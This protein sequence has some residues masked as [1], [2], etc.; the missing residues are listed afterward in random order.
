MLLEKIH[1]SGI[2]GAGGAG[3]PTSKKLNAKAEYLI[4]NAAECEPLLKTDHY[5]MKHFAKECIQAI[6]EVGKIV[7]CENI[8][9]AT[10]NY[11]HEEIACLEA[12][13]SEQNAPITIH[14]MENF[15]PAGDE[16]VMV[17]EV[18]GR[19]VP[20]T[21]IPL[22]VGC[23][24][25]NITTM[26]NI[27]EA[28]E[29]EKPVTE[30]LVTITGAVNKPTMILVPIGTSFSTCLELAGG[31]PL[32]QFI[33]LNGGPMM[34]KI[35]NHNNFHDQVVTK[36]TSGIIILEEKEYLYSLHERQMSQIITQAKAACIQC[37]LCTQLCPRFQ[38]GIPLHPHQVMRHLATS[39]VPD[40]ID[41]DPVWKQAILCCEC[42]ICEVIACPMALSP[43]QVN[44]YVKQR[45][46]E[47]GIR[48]E[49]N[50]EELIPQPMREYQK[51]PP[52]NILLKM[53]LEQYVD[54][55][56]SQL[57]TFEPDEV[58]IPL[59]M[60]IGAPCQP[61][62]KKGD[63]VIKG[64]LI[65]EMEDGKLGAPIH[66]SISGTIICTSDSLI[67]IKKDVA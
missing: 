13:I 63:Q 64:Q 34:G 65:A 18:T 50:G 41:D 14:K 67:Q 59:K 26:L 15:Y 24:V 46:A 29:H 36:T 51:T 23:I 3:F 56:L 38:I 40:D 61:L 55:D 9:I 27:Y 35:G 11:Y 37:R 39:D 7:E 25:S 1:N 20:P 16:Q 12:A 21:G 32:K 62:V 42:G 58:F 31:T 17:F 30:K 33:F 8:V 54:N 28:M 52:K 2:V 4:I 22:Q 47:K 53:G 19:T 10:K 5:V 48:Y 6:T 57:I 49:Y 44:I 43:R 66:A 45:L 60:H